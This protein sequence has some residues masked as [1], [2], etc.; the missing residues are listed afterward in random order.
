SF[1]RLRYGWSRVRAGEIL[2]PRQRLYYILN[3]SPTRWLNGLSLQG[4]VGEEVDFD[5]ARTGHGADV[6]LSGILRPT[7]HLEL[8]LNVSRRWL[9][10][11]PPDLPAGR[12]FTAQVERV[13][14]TYNF[15]ARAFLRLIA[16][17]VDT[18]RDPALYIGPVTPRDAS[19]DASALLAY[20]L[21]WQ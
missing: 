2:L 17:Y 8:R 4:F 20:K 14:A 16:Q 19:L 11:A 15:T 9:D 12:L 7:D 6:Q 13:R 21:N 5:N 1:L 3:A 10:E 18:R